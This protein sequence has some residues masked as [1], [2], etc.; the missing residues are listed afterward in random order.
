[1]DSTTKECF[2][3]S[4]Q[5]MSAFNTD[6]HVQ[7]LVPGHSSNIELRTALR[8]ND[9]NNGVYL[10][11]NAEYNKFILSLLGRIRYQKEVLGFIHNNLSVSTD[12][13]HM[14]LMNASMHYYKKTSATNIVFKHKTGWV[15][16]SSADFEEI[17][18]KQIA[19]FYA[20]LQQEHKAYQDL[21][22]SSTIQPET[23]DL[24]INNF[25]AYTPSI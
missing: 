14:S 17:C 9:A 11:N 10:I 16:L 6:T 2:T 21:T 25:M 19:F 4:T 5:E 12:R 18:D 7:I 13:D 24:I 3:Y 22:A 20:V 15:S 8:L 1:M 23:F